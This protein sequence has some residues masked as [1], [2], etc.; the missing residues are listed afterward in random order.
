MS[1]RVTFHSGHMQVV[2]CLR[3]RQ[4]LRHHIKYNEAYAYAF[5]GAA[6]RLVCVERFTFPRTTVSNSSRTCVPHL[7]LQKYYLLNF[8]RHFMQPQVLRDTG[9]RN[10]TQEALLL[11]PSQGLYG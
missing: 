3:A 11:C 8:T 5:P 7:R 2:R 1:S 10:L 4:S 6:C 9:W